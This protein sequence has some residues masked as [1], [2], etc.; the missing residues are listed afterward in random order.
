LQGFNSAADVMARLKQG[1]G[2]YL[3]IVNTGKWNFIGIGFTGPGDYW[4]I[5][6][7]FL[8]NPPNS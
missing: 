8:P 6:F 5:I 1:P 2:G 4:T 3:P 7:V